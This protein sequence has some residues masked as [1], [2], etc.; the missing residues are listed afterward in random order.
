VMVEAKAAPLAPEVYEGLECGTGSVLLRAEAAHADAYRWYENAGDGEA[1]VG[2]TAAEFITPDLE[3]SQT[4]FVSAV[5]GNCESERVAV[6]A[7]I[8]PKPEAYAGEDAKLALGEQIQLQASGG[9]SYR[10]SP[11]EGLNNAQIPDPVAQPEKTITYTLTVT[12][13]NGCS[14]VD[15][16]TITIENEVKEVFIPNA[17]SPN[18]DGVN[19]VWEIFN[20]DIYPDCKISVFDRWGNA[21]FE[22]AGYQDPWNGMYAGEVLPAGSY[23]FIIQLDADHTPI[24]GTLMIIY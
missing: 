14:A 11:A 10:W 1:I 21:V 18:N 20:I 19:D 5:Y 13:E 22:S 17:F 12:N 2:E 15:E 7:T 6:N 3:S 8:E 24:T 9:V 4:Y 23:A 16:I